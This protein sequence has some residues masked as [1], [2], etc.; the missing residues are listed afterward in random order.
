MIPQRSRGLLFSALLVLIAVIVARCAWA[1]QAATTPQA[2]FQRANEQYRQAHFVEAADGYRIMI[3]S[4]V[5]NGTIYY[6]LG[7]ALIKSGHKGE[8][9]W[10]Y[11]NAQ[12]RLP[13]DPDL[14]AN[15]NYVQSLLSSAEA[16]VKPPRLIRWLTLQQSFTTS[17]LVL[18]V[19]V[20]LWMTMLC[21]VASAWIP[22]IKPGMRPVA[23]LISVIAALALAVLMAQTIWIDGVSNAVIIRDHADVKFSPQPTGTTHFTLPEGSVVRV[24][25]RDLGWVQV[26]RADGRS[27]WVPDEA[28]RPL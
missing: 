18:A 22:G 2:L 3:R 16:S 12:R 9:L 13:R 6:N 27:G 17:E 14:R 8:A 4:G 26:K 11:L 25:G 7:N 28:V 19:A 20:L 5:E 21:W 1:E 24:L 15:L 10:A 23:R